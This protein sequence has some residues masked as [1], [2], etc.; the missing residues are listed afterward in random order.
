MSQDTV[1]APRRVRRSVRT[2]AIVA[3]IVLVPMAAH[4]LWDYLE[5]RRLVAEIEEIKRRGEPVTGSQAGALRQPGKDSAG[6]Y[7]LAGAMLALGSNASRDTARFR[8]WAILAPA[9]EPPPPDLVEALANTVR[10]NTDALSLADEG[11]RRVFE[12]LPPGTEYSYRASSLAALSTMVAARTLHEATTGRG[13]EAVES[14]L[15]WLRLRQAIRDAL[16]V[17]VGTH[18]VPVVLSLSRPSDVALGRLQQ[19]L[20]DAERPTEV[21]DTLVRERAR[22]LDVV[23]RRH[24]GATP[25]APGAFGMPI[26]G[27]L[28]RPIVSRNA[29]SALRVWATLIDLAGRPRAEW[30][31][32]YEELT[33]AHPSP[34]R[35]QAGGIFSTM[36][37]A[38]VPLGLFGAAMDGDSLVAD[39]A[40]R[41]AVAVERYRRDHEDALPVSLDDVVPVYLDAVPVDPYAGRPL[42]YLASGIGYTI[43]SVGPDLQD[44]GG[45][46]TSETEGR[47]ARGA[48]TAPIRGADVGVRI[49]TRR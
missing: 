38:V 39:R 25:D 49:T 34:R 5:I 26:S 42:R 2:L 45:D 3:C 31:A 11:A 48:P 17:S 29:V 37:G 15:V 36:V 44:D 24:Y 43:Y 22:Y 1:T 40:A 47:L 46:L 9:E 16:W 19:A 35:G 41:A 21:L 12:G 32:R 20:E 8:Q 10:D 33:M 6:R 28:V 13:D 4:R 7:Y 30:R 27:T 23:W 18:D 14:A